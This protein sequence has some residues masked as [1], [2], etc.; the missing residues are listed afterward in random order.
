MREQ[1]WGSYHAFSKKTLEL[2]WSDLESIVLWRFEINREIPRNLVEERLLELLTDF[3]SCLEIER[4]FRVHVASEHKVDQVE[5]Y[6]EISW[7][8]LS[9]NS[10]KH[11]L[12]EDYWVLDLIK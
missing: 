3:N 12:N 5:T 10:C 2:L 7:V 8:L 11:T 9:L 1:D 6:E 4:A